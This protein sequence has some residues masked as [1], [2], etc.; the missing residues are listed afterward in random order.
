[1]RT[2]HQFGDISAKLAG[3]FRLLGRILTL[4]VAV[5]GGYDITVDLR[6]KGTDVRRDTF[7]AFG[8]RRWCID[9]AH[10]VGPE[11]RMRSCLGV[12]R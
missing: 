5:E 4:E 1:M 7:R 10:M 3:Q 8:K 2:I 11:T 9:A 6:R 12:M